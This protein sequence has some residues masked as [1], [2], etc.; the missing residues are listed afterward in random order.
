VQVGVNYPW[1]D[2]GW[3]FGGPPSWR[4][5]KAE[6]RWLGEIDDHL[7]RFDALGITVVRWFVLADGLTYGIGCDVPRRDP[8]AASG[9]A[10]DPPALGADVLHWFEELLRRF[11]RANQYARQPLQLLPVLIDFHFCMSCAPTKEPGWMKR[12]RAGALRD[13]GKRR[14]FLDATLA[15][16]LDVSRIHA[17]CI[18]AWELINEPD[19]ITSG[20]HPDGKTSHPVDEPSM[21]AF[22][23]DG[24]RRIREAG[25][26]STVGFGALETLRRSGIRADINQFHHYPGGTRRLE[27]HAFDPGY[28][29]VIGEF[30]TASD[31]V[32]PELVGNQTLFDRLQFAEGQGYPLAIPWSFLATDRHTRWSS[33]TERDLERFALSR[34]DA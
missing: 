22:L 17:D 28:P 1:R 5:G 25:M 12:G 30:A 26:Q 29:A 33:D 7:R 2:Y 11:E 15:P 18:Y 20:W 14:L 19:W 13:P 32:W 10:F 27:P 21:R 31:D 16:L 9:W 34:R 3:D 24:I 8:G 23:D 6:P 4:R